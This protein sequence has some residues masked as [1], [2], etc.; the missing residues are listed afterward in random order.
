MRAHGIAGFP[1]PDLQGQLTLEMVRAAGIDLR[2]QGV[3]VA[4]KACAGASHGAI[5]VADVEA[6]VNG[7][8]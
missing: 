7:A 5:S 6:A 4:G 2:S 8:H 3:L 1:D